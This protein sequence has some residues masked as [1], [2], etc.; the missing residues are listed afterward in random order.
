MFNPILID[1]LVQH[2]GPP[3]TG[4]ASVIAGFILRLLAIL[5]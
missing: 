3:A 1:F 5:F 2:L 4:T